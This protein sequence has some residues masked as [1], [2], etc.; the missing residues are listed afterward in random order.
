MLYQQQSGSGNT[1]VYAERE[2]TDAI[3]A[4]YDLS[5]VN[6]FKVAKNDRG[7]V[8]RASAARADGTPVRLICL[9]SPSGTVRDITVEHR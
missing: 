3:R 1:S 6:V 7:F 4:R 5:N 2:C 8:V 9:T